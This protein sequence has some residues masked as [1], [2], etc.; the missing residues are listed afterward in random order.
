[1]RFILSIH[2]SIKKILKRLIYLHL[3]TFKLVIFCHWF[4]N[5]WNLETTFLK[6]CSSKNMM[7][8]SSTT[9]KDIFQINVLDN[10]IFYNLI[11]SF[12]FQASKHFNV[13]LSCLSF[14]KFTDVKNMTWVSFVN[15]LPSKKNHSLLYCRKIN[16]MSLSQMKKL[17][18]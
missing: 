5:H 17:D 9:G 8:F 12:I 14:P 16:K 18:L 2:V 10:L 13:F 11:H 1:M 3:C 7:S 15:P 6:E 4:T